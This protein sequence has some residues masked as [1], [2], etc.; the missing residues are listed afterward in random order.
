MRIRTLITGA[1]ATAL[2]GAGLLATSAKA[3]DD[4][5]DANVGGGVAGIQATVNIYSPTIF[6]NV[7]N[8][9][10][11][12]LTVVTPRVELGKNGGK[13]DASVVN[14]AVGPV[15]VK[16]IS[17]TIRGNRTGLPYATARSVLTGISI[18]ATKIGAL[19]VNCTWD[20]DGARGSTTLVEANG[21]KNA[22]APNTERVIP[23]LGTLVLNEQFIDD[24]YDENPPDSGVYTHYQ[25]IYVY[26]AHLYLTA[27]AQ[28]I[29]NTADVI[30]G[31]TSCD[32]V[33][34]PSLSGLKLGQTST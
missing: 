7:N 28:E 33:R 21:T 25:V 20:R 24:Y 3:A 1:V 19:D 22:P 5:F 30:L 8:N 16:A 26:G 13:K 14:K 23:G 32:P 4:P 29:Y 9:D 31:F 10:Y 18:G 27:D 12:T 17:E 11:A 34:L 15:S 6:N 2:V